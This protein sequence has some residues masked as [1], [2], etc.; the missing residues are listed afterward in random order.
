MGKKIGA[1]DGFKLGGKEGSDLVS[2]DVSFGGLNG[3]NLKGAVLGYGYPLGIAEVIKYG[4]TLGKT[5]AL[6]VG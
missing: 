1:A 5:Y 6:M 3:G 2:S 4:T